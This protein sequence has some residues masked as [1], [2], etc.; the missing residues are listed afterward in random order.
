[1]ITNANTAKQIS[2]LMLDVFR[3]VDESVAMVKKTC[4]PEEAAAYQK[5]V[6][7]VA[8]PIV[9]DVLEPLYEKNPTLKLANWDD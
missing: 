6:G 5:A 8:G 3:R 1:V 4:S 9:M 2:E 7:R